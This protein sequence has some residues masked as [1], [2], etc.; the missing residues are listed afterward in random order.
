MNDQ[1][2]AKKQSGPPNATFADFMYAVVIGV[3]FSD[4]HPFDKAA[5]F[6]SNFVTFL[7]LI[8]VLEDFYL[9]QTEV[10]PYTNV[11]KFQ[12]FSSLFFE[13]LILLCWY[14]AFAGRI[15]AQVGSLLALAAF[16]FLKWAASVKHLL[17]VRQTWIIHRDHLFW[18]TII[19]SVAVAIKHIPCVVH[20]GRAN[21]AVDWAVFA[22]AWFLQTV[23]WWTVVARHE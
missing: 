23:L 21:L 5:N 22:V 6:Q 13:V 2:S 16:F 20:V 8:V 19:V 10:K 7:L 18:I 3:A 4:I 12:G 11:F 14:I 1:D 17:K 15:E 9:Y